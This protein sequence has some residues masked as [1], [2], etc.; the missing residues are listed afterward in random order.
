MRALAPILKHIKDMSPTTGRTLTN[1]YTEAARKWPDRDAFYFI[2]EDRR[3][4]FMELD[5]RSNQLANLLTRRGF[6]KGDICALYMKNRPEFEAELRGAPATHTK[7][8][9]QRPTYWF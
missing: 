2:D 3:M 8:N 9:T 4:T 7:G 1:C 5:R 6:A